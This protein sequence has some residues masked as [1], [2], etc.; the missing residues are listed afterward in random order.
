MVDDQTEAVIAVTV[1]VLAIF[2][3]FIII[4]VVKR[5]RGLQD[6]NERKTSDEVI[7]PFKLIKLSGPK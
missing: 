5:R 2:V 3:A 6:E 1:V 7:F 4:C